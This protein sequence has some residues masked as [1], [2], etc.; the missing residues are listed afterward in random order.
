MKHLKNNDIMK[1]IILVVTLFISVVNCYSQN[2]ESKNYY[3]YNGEKIIIN[4]NKKRF[5]VYYNVDK[6]PE[7]L[8]KGEYTV[9]RKIN[10]GSTS[11]R[12]NGPVLAGYELIINGEEN[13]ES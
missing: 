9:S 5:V 4:I 10:P 2:I 6:E 8:L 3:Y 13:Y 11:R 1:T 12:N 7:Q